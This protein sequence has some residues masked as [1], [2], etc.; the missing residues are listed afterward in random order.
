MDIK[1]LKKIIKK[2]GD[3]TDWYY[4][5]S[6]NVKIYCEVSRH[7]KMGTL[8]GYVTL[9][10]VDKFDMSKLSEEFLVRKIEVHGGVTYTRHYP[11]DNKYVIGFDCAHY[12]DLVPSYLESEKFGMGLITGPCYREMA[13][14]KSECE[15]LAEQISLLD[16]SYIRY[17]KLK[18]IYK[19]E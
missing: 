9:S 1:V 8:N 12:N 5:T 13:Y 7:E 15:S 10:E 2:E 16:K 19:N 11:E 17:L 6:N 3:Y 4:D 14:V 18:N